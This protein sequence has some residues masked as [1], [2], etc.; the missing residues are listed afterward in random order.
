MISTYS[1]NGYGQMIMDEIRTSGYL[2]ALGGAIKPGAVVLDIG[3]GTGIFAMMAC[4]CGA[5]RVYA[6]D[7]SDLVHLGRELAA[8][9]GY[10]DRIHFI[11][12]ISTRITLPEPVDV[13]VSDIRGALP[14]FQQIIPTIVDA[15]RRFL[16]PG[17]RLIPQ[18]DTLWAAVVELPEVYK[19][20]TSPWDE[21]V[22]GLDLRAGR[23]LAI[24]TSYNITIMPENLLAPPRCWWTIN[25]YTVSEPDAWAELAWTVAQT[26]TAHGIAIWFDTILA[27]GVSFSNGPGEKHIYG[28]SFFPWPEPM[29]LEPG[30]LV[31]VNLAA[32][33]VGDDYLWRWDSRILEQGRPERVK[34]EFRQST[35]E[36]AVFSAAALRQRAA[37]HVPV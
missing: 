31:T 20:Y 19:K 6:I 28:R 34:G 18:E 14:F 21:N 17:G 8:A 5:A 1:L 3:T 24:N 4:R 22:Y 29:N 23:P 33:L 37:G 12:G 25:Y 2:E 27:P 7:P 35:F 26:G 10:A 32:N 13:I 30:D 15:R 36:G 11:Q 9:N 16:A